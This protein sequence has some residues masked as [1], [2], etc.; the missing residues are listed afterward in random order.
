MRLTPWPRSVGLGRGA[1]SGSSVADRVLSQLLSEMD[2]I[3]SLGS[4]TV[5]AATNRPDMIDPALLRPGRIDRMIYV[6]PP[7]KD[8]RASIFTR[9]LANVPHNPDVDIGYLSE[10]TSGCSGAEVA[11]ICR[12][13]GLGAIKESLQEGPAKTAVSISAAN[14]EHALSSVPRRIN[15]EMLDF[16]AKYNS[17][18]LN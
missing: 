6:G 16:Y 11:A 8:A 7:D 17:S 15:M 5:V 14:F 2:G 13:A 9:A 12:E 4:V 3:E 10:K 18:R 1:D